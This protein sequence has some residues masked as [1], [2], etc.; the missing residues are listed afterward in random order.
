MDSLLIYLLKVS[1][2]TTL[3]YLCYL[4]FF[5][6]DT[7]YLRNRILLIMILL[8]P[9]VF[10]AFKIP[11]ALNI[12]APEVQQLQTT[13]AFLPDGMAGVTSM[14]VENSFDYS[15][16][17]VLIYYILT[18]LFLSRVIISLVRTFCIIKKGKVKVSQ[19][20]KVVVSDDNVPPFSFFPFAVIPA[21]VYDS[22]NYADILDHEFAHIRQGHT[23]DLLL[24]ELI[25][26]IQWFNPVIWFMKRS[27]IL[28]HEY[29]A[30]N[31]SLKDKGI[32]EYQYRLLN[33]QS[34]L[35]HISLAHNFDSLIK[36]R[37]IMINKKPSGKIAVLKNLLLLPLAI[38]V[39][40]AFATPEYHYIPK[41]PDT[42]TI[43]A[44][45][46]IIQKEVRGTVLTEAGTPI[47]KACAM[48]TGTPGNSSM[49]FTGIDG[50]FSISNI[51]SDA[52]LI[53]S[54]IGFK[55]Q[56]I[57]A[58]FADEMIVKLI[59]NP[60]YTGIRIP[61]SLQNALIVIDGVI[62]DKPQADVLRDINVVQIENMSVIP[63]NAG[64]R[65]YGEQGKNGVIEISTKKK[66]TGSG[67]KVPYIRQTADDYPTFQGNP[68]GSFKDWLRGKINYPSEAIAKGISGH[69]TAD[70]TVESDGSI[71]KVTLSGK[72]DPLLG[73]L[74]LKAIKASPK[75]E[76]AKN[77]K[78]RDPFTSTVSLFFELPGKISEDDV[79]E[80]AEIMP[81]YTWGEAAL[82]DF[83][84][85]NTRYPEAAAAEKIEG[86]VFV[87]FIVNKN[88]DAEEPVILKGVH[89]LL[90]AEALRVIGRIREFD[91]G[92]QGG[93]P[94]K[95]Y[96]ILPV[97]FSL[98]EPGPLFSSASE[99][100]ILKFLMSNTAYPSGAK[101]ASD[102]GRIYVVVKLDKGGIIK[103][104]NAFTEKTGIKA[105]FLPEMVIAGY[106]P[107][108]GQNINNTVN[109][110]VNELQ[111]LKSE[112]IRVT[113]RLGEIDIPEW[114]DK[115]ME[116][117]LCYK[118]VLINA[119]EASKPLFDT[120][121]RVV[122]L[123]KLK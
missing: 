30:D 94:V 68:Y 17:I 20:P 37:I 61:G 109:T 105:P 49:V 67:I 122:D 66:T 27:V 112:C 60:D 18:G 96:H 93:N 25:I 70:Y 121:T 107:A 38:F 42:V 45:N 100:K 39:A 9:A 5:S 58:D 88:G 46:E 16:L 116:F 90:D 98:S 110:E 108:P 57:K 106:K 79:Y 14:S 1:A 78:A 62:S 104:C 97:N 71:K 75:W 119:R 28:N 4:L 84:K 33:F 43:A 40:Y 12:S 54:C 56:T 113:S 48:N 55:S 111:L 59:K 44:E 74:V 35:K 51:P 36:N 29:L 85:R 87:R 41:V 118:F 91:P 83:I 81:K 24:I 92:Y 23:F 65:K 64:Q 95:V 117:T 103:E 47:E 86:R 8:L 13:N 6:R 34:G 11:V 26:S 63:G 72:P 114:K 123:V 76:P 22:E 82:S 15:G 102:T 89:P 32:K 99:H 10:P 73:D 77:Q 115:N 101:I 3:L 53:F 19:F 2:A 120:G 69:I 80:T 52:S 21:E 7:F 31:V 50:R